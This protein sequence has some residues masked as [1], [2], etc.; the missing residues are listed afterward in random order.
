[1]C[2]SLSSL[3]LSLL[4]VVRLLLLR[5]GVERN[6]GPPAKREKSREK[7][8]EKTPSKKTNQID[9]K[10]VEV[11]SVPA[12][13]ETVS[14]AEVVSSSSP[15]V[16][17]AVGA[18][19]ALSE[20]IVRR[21]VHLAQ[22]A[23]EVGGGEKSQDE[24]NA[25]SS[26]LPPPSN[27]SASQGGSFT[28]DPVTGLPVNTMPPPLSYASVAGVGCCPQPDF[29]P[30][31]SNW[32]RDAFL[33]AL[34]N[35]KV[36]PLPP[37]K[38]YDPVGVSI[39]CFRFVST[40]LCVM[41]NC[42]Y[43]HPVGEVLATIK[44]R[45]SASGHMKVPFV[46]MAS[47]RG[48]CKAGATAC[49]YVHLVTAAH[50]LAQEAI[51]RNVSLPAV[52]SSVSCTDWVSRVRTL[53]AAAPPPPPPREPPIFESPCVD[54]L[55]GSCTRR[56]CSRVHLVGEEFRRAVSRLA[57]GRQVKTNRLCRLHLLGTCGSSDAGC[58][59][60]HLN[61]RELHDA[62]A[63]ALAERKDL[64]TL[65]RRSRPSV[66]L[67]EVAELAGSKAPFDW[68]EGTAEVEDEVVVPTVFGYNPI[69]LFRATRLGDAERPLGIADLCG[70]ACSLLTAVSVGEVT[71][72]TADKDQ[73]LA[74]PEMCAALCASFGT[75][76]ALVSSEDDAI[77]AKIAS[78]GIVAASGVTVASTAVCV[79]LWE[80]EIPV[81]FIR[82]ARLGW[83]R[84]NTCLQHVF[85]RRVP[86]AAA[87]LSLSLG[88]QSPLS[89]GRGGDGNLPSSGRKLVQP[90][91][92]F[93]TLEVPHMCAFGALL[94]GV[95]REWCCHSASC[96]FSLGLRQYS[97][98]VSQIRSV[99]VTFCGSNLV[100][101]Q[102][103][104]DDLSC[105]LAFIRVREEQP[106]LA[107]VLL[108][109][110]KVASLAPL[111]CW[112]YGT[113]F[114][115]VGS[116]VEYASESFAVVE[117]QGALVTLRDA[118][119]I[120]IPGIMATLLQPSVA[121][122]P[123]V[124]IEMLEEL[125]LALGVVG[126]LSASL[127]PTPMKCGFNIVSWNVHS[128]TL[129]KLVS[130][131]A[132]F[133]MEQPDVVL[134]QEVWSPALEVLDA[135]KRWQC[136]WLLRDGELGGGVAVLVRNGLT[137]SVVPVAVLRPVECLVVDVACGETRLRIGSLYS[138][139]HHLKEDGVALVDA[140][141]LLAS[142]G[143]SV[144]GDFNASH[145]S[146]CPSG[147]SGKVAR[148]GLAVV[149]AMVEGDFA[150]V[151][152]KQPTHTHGRVLDFLLVSP[153]CT[154]PL[155]SAVASLCP[156]AL[157]SDHVPVVFTM[158]S[159]SAQRGAAVV[160]WSRVTPAHWKTF[161]QALDASLLSG[162][163]GAAASI[164]VRAAALSER[165]VSA[166]RHFPR[167]Y[168]RRGAPCGMSAE[169]A[170][171]Q[172]NANT[173]WQ[174]GDSEGIL[175]AESAFRAQVILDLQK[176]RAVAAAKAAHD[177]V[178][179]W[180]LWS[181]TESAKVTDSPPGSIRQQLRGFASLFAGKHNGTASVP[182]SVVVSGAFASFSVE[183]L[184]A[185]ILEQRRNGS[186]DP[187]GV[188]PQ[189]VRH[190]TPLFR[191]AFLRLVDEVM[192]TGKIPQQWRESLLVPV[193][194]DNKDL[195]E[196]GSF[197]PV[198]LTSL[199]CRLAERMILRRLMFVVEPRLNPQQYGFLPG[200]R[201]DFP[202]L[203]LLHEVREKL[204]C[205]SRVGAAVKGKDSRPWSQE[206]GAA[207][208]VDFCDAFCRV[209]VTEVHDRLMALKVDPF[210]V[211]FV[212]GWLTRRMISVRWC[213]RKSR[214]VETVLGAPQGSI[215]GPFL[216]LL[217]AD[218]LS[219]ILV[220]KHQAFATSVVAFGAPLSFGWIAD[221]LTVWSVGRP[222]HVTARLKA[223]MVD[224]AAWALARE[225]EISSKTDALQFG[226]SELSAGDFC[227]PVWKAVTPRSVF[228]SDNSANGPLRLLGVLL[229]TTL[230]FSG[231]VAFLVLRLEKALVRLRRLARYLCP[232]ELR[233]LFFGVGV[234]V[235][236]FA[237]GAW[238][239]GL[240][241]GRKAELETLYLAFARVISGCIGTTEKNAVLAEAHL[242]P[243]AFV[244]SRACVRCAASLL[245]LP[246]L[247][248]TKAV[249][250][251]G[252]AKADGIGGTMV[253]PLAPSFFTDAMQPMLATKIRVMVP[254][255]HNPA[256]AY[257]SNKVRFV[258][259][260]SVLRRVGTPLRE[261]R[262]YNADTLLSLAPSV[263]LVTDGSVP[264]RGGCGCARLSAA[265][266]ECW[267]EASAGLC[268]SSCSAEMVGIRTAVDLLADSLHAL[269]PSPDVVLA[270]DS[271][272]SVE[273][274]ALGPFESSDPF[275]IWPVVGAL[276]SSGSI[277]SFTLV[278]IFAHCGFVDGDVVDVRA[279]EVCVTLAHEHVPC[280]AQDIANFVVR[281]LRA[282]ALK[283]MWSKMTSVRRLLG[284]AVLLPEGQADLH[285]KIFFPFAPLPAHHQRLL[286]QL[287]AGACGVLGGWRHERDDPCL[288]CGNATAL[289]RSGKATQHVFLCPAMQAE[290]EEVG[291]SGV[292]DLVV[293]P[294]KA[295]QYALL[296]L[297]RCK[298]VA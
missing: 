67:A 247:P 281:P 201:T 277:A 228:A 183:E 188:P 10:K 171:L 158:T 193:P 279:G 272:S 169:A 50:V 61:S 71:A 181:G 210:L 25:V 295:I 172:R 142:V 150:L 119:G 207:V 187:F 250:S 90:G 161:E 178:L 253:S 285:D 107:E 239:P 184:D 87:Y 12:P 198:A 9:K 141:R 176:K 179:L 232:Q 14:V 154:L 59:N 182:P 120:E 164:S 126:L 262:D 199:L 200:R 55:C 255:R 238:W 29:P 36:R 58:W 265:G 7:M 148:A 106:S 102:G 4:S 275:G 237:C 20:Q 202:V 203:H 221:D 92:F 68:P 151:S 97:A 103:A 110:P 41:S 224:V 278:F 104:P 235:L 96:C 143:A 57:E 276:L 115:V 166:C 145:P 263:L 266:V 233:T 45:V 49:K 129:E 121:A 98:M 271:R 234:S 18:V 170:Q 206:R 225:I 136:F 246:Q 251:V 244:M 80:K 257:C 131:E 101:E 91:P 95:V 268:P 217:I 66:A 155:E 89:L 112:P 256:S 99:G 205:S 180:R 37:Q 130:F 124:P 24:G 219:S 22:E 204:R 30:P 149:R 73:T 261:L 13:V 63:V 5:G 6:P 291:V 1:M 2:A 133:S 294:V 47:L 38:V 86:R 43:V 11:V 240:S 62:A 152:P 146:W 39:P 267:R 74:V 185:A 60:V 156:S 16:H 118:Q 125:D 163:V 292:V 8:R 165:V 138:P 134:L 254:L 218:T 3:S 109:L 64:P 105:V 84:M 168:F 122:A 21:V 260:P 85:A 290:R 70:V 259:P 56:V 153:S 216:W 174:G 42:R 46:C 27:V 236:S 269:P 282:L 249:R 82:S 213:G 111:P 127:L 248:V 75:P 144:A 252:V 15:L 40:G 283:E 160:S 32:F 78:A 190:L 159:V 296:Y 186:T 26:A 280:L 147:A 123:P 230:T 35:A 196:F 31:S 33:L 173:A 113:S 23:S 288:L 223:V 273:T 298:L 189:V 28:L 88:E 81:L 54:F 212:V 79:F 297:N 108:Q 245:A 83:Y 175:V 132:A 135:L 51:A 48:V 258:L 194:K 209:A 226:G 17:V 243:L 76:F 287:R 72:A 162:S 231:H 229:D 242:L 192:N 52:P 286:A 117:A 241:V 264:V 208:A 284:E 139:P 93:G 274:L 94:V 214:K 53:I 34:K 215:L 140:L 167:S 191:A 222:K 100:W 19:Q 211:R 197:R 157:G 227:E 177:P 270:T 220:R 69:S 128:L 289:G 65:P 195:R 137:A 114:P 77:A 116:C 44:A 293:S